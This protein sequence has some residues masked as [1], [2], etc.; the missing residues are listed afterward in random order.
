MRTHLTQADFR[1]D[2]IDLFWRFVYERQ[3]IWHRRCMEHMSPPWTDDCILRQERF[4]NVYRELDPGTQYALHY[5]LEVDA[6]KPDKIF[7]IMLYRLIG[8]A[9]THEALGF[10]SLTTFDPEYL[11]CVLTRLRDVDRRPPFTGAYMVS[12]YS[13]LGTRDKIAS[14]AHIFAAIQFRFPT[15]C[16]QIL[17]CSSA[18]EV[19][20]ELRQVYGFGNFLAY[21][22]LVDLLYPLQV[23]GGTPLLP[24]SHD[25]WASAGPGAR[26]GIRM[27]MLDTYDG[28]ELEIMRWLRDHQQAEFD[29]LGLRFR[30]LRDLQDEPVH[31]TLA[32]I[33]NCLCEFH[34]YVKIR[35]GT[36]RGRR[37]FDAPQSRPAIQLVLTPANHVD[38]I[39]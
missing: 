13:S 10:Q 28:N 39:L 7:N 37:R 23:Y 1:S 6:P 3:E 30:F 16:V 32:N 26:R 5:I 18:S 17:N 22:V 36:G 2:R 4:T 29:R 33:Q 27:L 21:Q 20:G 24:Y 11:T 25:E 31:I 35:E 9:E 8:R 34:K 19:Y 12:A 15:L 38:M 14:V